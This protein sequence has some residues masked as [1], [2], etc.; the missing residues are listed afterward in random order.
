M[1]SDDPNLI[2]KQESILDKLKNGG[3]G[4]AGKEKE[5][6]DEEPTQNKYS[7]QDRANFINKALKIKD[8]TIS[9]ED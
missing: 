8:G 4:L 7:S 3:F 6:E 5:S 1:K 9:V 2:V